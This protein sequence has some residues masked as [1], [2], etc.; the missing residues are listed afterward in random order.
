MIIRTKFHP[1]IFSFYKNAYRMYISLQKVLDIWLNERL[2]NTI[3]TLTSVQN[4]GKARNGKK[5]LNL[6]DPVNLWSVKKYV[7]STKK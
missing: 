4:F 7:L 3:K 6:N 5:R 1:W 2:Y